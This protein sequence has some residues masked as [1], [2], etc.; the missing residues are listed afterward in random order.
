M[1]IIVKTDSYCIRLSLWGDTDNHK[2]SQYLLSCSGITT[3]KI[4]TF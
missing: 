3:D 2:Q 1:I 4:P